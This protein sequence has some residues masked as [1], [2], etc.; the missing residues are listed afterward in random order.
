MQSA[1][2]VMAKGRAVFADK[3]CTCLSSLLPLHLCK[4][5]ALEPGLGLEDPWIVQ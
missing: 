4:D 3:I 5:L 2:D 1:M